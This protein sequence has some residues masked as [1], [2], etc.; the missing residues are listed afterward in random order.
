MSKVWFITGTSKGFGREFALAALERGD[1][2]AATAR[3]TDTLS[4]L[5]KQ[6]GDAVLPIK[7]DVTD[8]DQV[9]AAVKSAHETFGRIDVVINNA[10]YGLFGTVEEITE[11]QLRDQMETNLF[12]VFHVTQAVLPI[13]REQRAGHII[14]ISTMGGIMAFPTLG[15]YHA[16]KWALE[17]MTDALSQ[18]VTGFGIKVTLVEPGGF[19]TGWSGASAIVADA[20]PAYAPLHENMAARRAQ[21]VL[22]EPVGFRSAIL[23]VV[24]AEKPPLRVFFGEGPTFM[25]PQVYQQRLTEWAQWA[26]VSRAAEGK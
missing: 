24:D 19:A 1:K 12:G 16:S 22:P 11:Q 13:L 23:T 7:L 17:G 18:E 3:N 15:A 10:G 20:H 14:Q 9:F 26:H 2:V 6:Y 21:V 25:A 8:R 4:D 5:V